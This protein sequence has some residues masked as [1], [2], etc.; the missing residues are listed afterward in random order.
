MATTSVQ[1]TQ[2][3][4]PQAVK[5]NQYLL[6]L[7][8]NRNGQAT[9]KDPVHVVPRD[10]IIVLYRTEEIVMEGGQDL[11][12]GSGIDADDH[13][14]VVEIGTCTGVGDQD[15]AVKKSVGDHQDLAVQIGEVVIIVPLPDSTEDHHP[16]D[17]G[18]ASY[19]VAVCMLMYYIQFAY[20]IQY[21]YYS[22]V[23]TYVY[24]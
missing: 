17:T 20:I 24:T 2:V 8:S 23:C 12:V 18:L 19:F 21:I 16:Q 1:K 3:Q 10:M 14:P 6:K 7:F 11:A 22:F 5:I 15:R 13:D 4:I 9:G